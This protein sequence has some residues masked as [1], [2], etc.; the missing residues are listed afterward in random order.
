MLVL[1]F[2]IFLEQLFKTHEW[3]SQYL[4]LS[5]IAYFKVLS[6]TRFDGIAQ[7]SNRVSASQ[8]YICTNM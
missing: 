2:V 6:Y 4:Q 5:F 7:K 8:R 1:Y 3:N